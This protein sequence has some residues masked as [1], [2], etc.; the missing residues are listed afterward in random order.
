MKKVLLNTLSN[1]KKGKEKIVAITAYDYTFAR[2]IDQC[3][4]DIILVGDSLS[5]VCAGYKTTI[6]ITLDEMIYHCRSVRRGVNRSLLLGDLPFLSYQVSI[7]EAIRSAGRMMKEAEVEGVKLEGGEPLADTIYRLTE[8][9]IPVMGH[10]GFT[11]QSEHQLGRNVQGKNMLQFEKLKKEAIILEEAGA[12]GIVLELMPTE[13]AKEISES[14][15]IPTIG[16][17]AGGGCDGQIL[18]CYDLLGMDQEFSPKFLRKYANFCD[19][20]TEAVNAYAKDVQS[21]EYPNLRESYS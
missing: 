2:I 20:I 6:P 8:I 12:F 15:T 18:V 13:L 17:G 21:G 11:P 19:N 5:N 9:G 16:I 1:K 3:N 7:E 10:I 14:L 4:V